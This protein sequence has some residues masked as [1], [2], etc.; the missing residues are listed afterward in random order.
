MLV[1]IAPPTAADCVVLLHGLARSASAMEV[2]VKPLEA[3]G[4]RVTNIDYPSRKKKI[5][6]LAKPAI[7]K[8]IK[9]CALAEGEKLHFVTH[10]LG[11]ILV[12][13][14][15]QE[16]ELERLGRVVMLGPPNQ[17]SEVVD[18]L[19]GVPGYA[20]LNG[21]VGY[22][23]GT[24]KDSLPLSLPE[25]DYPVGV[26]A[27]TRSIDPVSSWILPNPDDG[28]VS[29]ARTKV[30]GMKAH[31]VLPVTHAFMM[32]DDEVH[33]QTIQFLKTGTF[34]QAP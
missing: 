33:R 32:R 2:M 12:R 24:G 18:K 14:Y 4:F 23:L 30:D 31:I 20:W 21:A 7:D 28:K 25:V 19:K 15:L 9:Q 1:L 22:Q 16:H 8:G 29:V 13:Y 10:S 6:A 5:E 34:D 26:I 17:G 11:G 3:E 27:G